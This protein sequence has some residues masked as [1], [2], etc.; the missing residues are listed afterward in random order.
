MEKISTVRYRQTLFTASRWTVG[1]ARRNV[2]HPEAAKVFGAPPCD[3]GRD[4]IEAMEM[5]LA[6]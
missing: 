6:R 5:L 4:P 3:E 1:P 2:Y